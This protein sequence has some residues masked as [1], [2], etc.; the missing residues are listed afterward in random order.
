M[1]NQNR[2]CFIGHRNIDYIA[3]KEKLKEVVKEEIENGCKFFT[4]GNHG[5]FDRLAYEVCSELRR[6]FKDIEIEVVVT[7][8]SQTKTIVEYYGFDNYVLPNDVKTVMYDIEE[9]HFKRRI[10]VSNQK[11]IDFCDTLIACVDEKKAYGGAIAAFKYAKKKGKKI[12][13]IYNNLL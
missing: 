8:L 7:T 6:T 13:N 5:R 9:E 10:T 11:M 2:V 1:K 4:M 3:I 12:K